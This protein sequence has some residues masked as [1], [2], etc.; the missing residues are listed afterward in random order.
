M[1]GTD[2]SQTK[3]EAAQANKQR[4]HLQLK[5]QQESEISA[6]DLNVSLEFSDC[7]LS[8]MMPVTWRLKKLLKKQPRNAVHQYVTVAKSAS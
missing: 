3:M 1:A 7:L 5:E 2:V 4:R 6:L 8:Q